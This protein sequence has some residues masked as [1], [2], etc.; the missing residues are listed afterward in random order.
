MV[1][2]Y[3]NNKRNYLKLLVIDNEP[4][5]INLFVYLEEH[6]DFNVKFLKSEHDSF[7][8]DGNEYEIVIIDFS[9]EYALKIHDKIL[10]KNPKQK[11]ITM[12]YALESSGKDKG[13]EYC[14]LH[15]NKKRVMK[16]I[17]TEELA[18]V[19]KNFDD[20]TC[21]YANKF[22]SP[23]SIVHILD[24]IM[25]HYY[26]YSYDP[27]NKVI[28]IDKSADTVE[29]ILNIENILKKSNISYVIEDYNK[30]RVLD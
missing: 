2:S 12:S 27:V 14:L 20:I 15:Y 5:V 6:S 24:K 13:C 10:E 29:S 21:F 28:L 9:L 17:K 8:Y 3:Y 11:M 1:Y 16:P 25:K 22:N 26:E 30:I 19:L 18:Q 4:D 23:T 7:E